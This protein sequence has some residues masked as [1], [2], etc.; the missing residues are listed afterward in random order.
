MRLVAVLALATVQLAAQTVTGTL[1]GRILDSS[2]AAITSAKV[3][4]KGLETGLIRNTTTNEGGYYQMTFIPLSTY[5]VTAEAPG[6]ASAQRNALV[7]LN[8]S[9]VVDFRLKPAAINTEVTVE[10]EAPLIE[11]SSGQIR[12]SID[13]KTIEDRPLSSRNILSLVEMLPGFQ[14]SG[15]YSGVNNPTLSSGSY[16]SFSGTGSRSAAFQIDGVGNDDSSEGSNRQN[17]NISTIKEFQVLTNAYPAEFGRAGGA[18]VLV[19]TK[20]G[21]NRIHGDAYEYLQNQ[22]LNSNGFFAN[23]AGNKPG[24]TPVSPRAPYRRN[25]FGYTVGGPVI[26]NKLFFFHSLERTTLRQ[27]NTFTRWIFL[28]TDKIEIG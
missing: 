15:G 20:S 9:R 19:Q 22:A 4:L 11:I 27:Y 8:A 26:K 3:S 13:E 10:A 28:P 6:F 14:S 23:S 12:N 17:V 24:G 2:G 7:E 18:V 16:V 5:T 1:E 25:Q 21:A